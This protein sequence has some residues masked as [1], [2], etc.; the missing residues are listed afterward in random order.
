MIREKKLEL[1]RYCW[2]LYKKKVGNSVDSN[3]LMLPADLG[4]IFTFMYD[5]QEFVCRL[6]FFVK[7]FSYKLFFN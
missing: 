6:L 2:C 1:E 4:A 5:T 7:S 3:I